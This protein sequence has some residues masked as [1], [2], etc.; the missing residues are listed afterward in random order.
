MAFDYCSDE[1]AL[2]IIA[3]LTE[4][5]IAEK[6][7]DERKKAEDKGKIFDENKALEESK[8][9]VRSTLRSAMTT[10]YKDL[11]CA[12]YEAS[13]RGEMQRI[14]DIIYTSGLYVEENKYGK[15]IFDKNVFDEW[16]D[17]WK[18]ENE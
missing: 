17:Q 2:E 6:L 5:K 18:K 3:E 7:D 8:K 13:N 16:I 11:Y 14:E 9:S 15:L 1:L 10:Y 4:L 12:A